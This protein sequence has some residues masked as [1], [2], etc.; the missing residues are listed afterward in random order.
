[1]IAL[2]VSQGVISLGM[3]NQDLAKIVLQIPQHC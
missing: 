3:E 1:M 2:F